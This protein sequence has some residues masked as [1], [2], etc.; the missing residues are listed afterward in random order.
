MKKRI[1]AAFMS[2]VLIF[3]LTSCD[4]NKG[5]TVQEGMSNQ[6]LMKMV[7][8]HD[9]WVYGAGQIDEKNTQVAFVASK[10]DGSEK[11]IIS[12]KAIPT[13]VNVYEDNLYYLMQTP[14]GSRMYKCDMD[15]KNEKEVLKG[16]DVN[17]YQIID[18][19]IYYQEFDFVFNAP[20]GV[21]S[22]DMD[23][24]NKKNIIKDPVLYPYVSG[25]KIYYQNDL[26]DYTYYVY[27][28][29]TKKK[30]KIG[31]KFTYMLAVDGEYAYGIETKKYFFDE[32]GDKGK[33]VKINLEDGK[34]EELT[35]NAYGGFLQVTDKYLYYMDM[36]KGALSRIKKD[37]SDKETIVADKNI[38]NMY[39]YGNDFIYI[40]YNDVGYFD[41]VYRCN[42]KGEDSTKL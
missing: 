25:D 4:G 20:L 14:E 7:T 3:T 23:G 34:K 19:K 8:V 27:D 26:E 22:C 37:G 38:G 28:M 32:G 12:R 5:G 13:Y 16:V 2:F 30:K 31:D 11:K 18:G 15:G 24:K 6:N 35:D 9:G 33:L 10:L 21:W 40:T 1:L 39:V 42:P 36:E 29:K 17:S 41:Q